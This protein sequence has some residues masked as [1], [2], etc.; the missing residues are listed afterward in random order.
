[1]TTGIKPLP[2]Q[3]KMRSHPNHWQIIWAIAHKDLAEISTNIQF[4][5]LGL[6]PVVVFLLYRLMVS[7]I[8]NSSMLDIAV[9]DPGNSQLV[10]AMM[11]QPDLELHIVESETALQAKITEGEMSGLHIP[12]NFDADVAAGKM[13]GLNIWL[14][15]DNGLASETARWQRF[16]E[17]EI[18]T[19]GQQTLP[20]QLE[21]IIVEN[22]SFA[23]DT[24]LDNYLLIIVL[25]MVCFI[26]GA[27]LVGLLI[28]EEKEKNLGVMLINSPAR[29]YHIVLGKALAG[30]VC[31]MLVL[32]LVI[33][34]NGGLTGNRAMALLYLAVTLLVSVCFGILAGSL[35]QS[36][37]QCNSWLGIAMLVL[38]IPAWFS[39]LL[40]LPEPFGIIFTFVPTHYLV[41]GLSDA[42]NGSEVGLVNNNLIIWLA[43]AGVLLVLTFWRI[44]QN[45]RSL[46]AQT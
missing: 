22:D 46:V 18:H 7:G 39:T 45:P 27:N 37:K 3:S 41:E 10:T 35:V 28:T 31:I 42:L 40:E 25:T 36:S 9:Y 17:T 11:S 32:A 23:S 34:L 4:I 43:F 14:N 13:P 26:S 5:M 2:E 29:P 24:V 6:T 20:A 38:L 8:D 30:A 16:I 12:A 44:R 33:L 21:W 1:M 15:P 19:L